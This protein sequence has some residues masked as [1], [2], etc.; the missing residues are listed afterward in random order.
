M[1]MNFHGKVTRALSLLMVAA[2]MLALNGCKAD[3]V[4][5]PNLRGPSEYALSILMT[6]NPDFVVSDGITTSAIG[7]NVRDRDGKAVPNLA[8]VLFVQGPGSLDRSFVTTNASGMASVTYTSQ[9]GVGPPGTPSTQVVAR[10]VGLDFTGETYRSVTI[11][12]FNPA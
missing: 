2:G 5:I 11:E 9:A 4:N 10:P 3:A 1:Q 12:I 7:V 8:I 6:A